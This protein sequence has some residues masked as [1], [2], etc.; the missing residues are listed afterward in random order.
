MASLSKNS[1]QIQEPASVY[2]SNGPNKPKN[3]I[4]K[5]IKRGSQIAQNNKPSTKD[6]N[7]ILYPKEPPPRKSSLRRREAMNPI[8]DLKSFL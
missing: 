7:S 3:Q 6:M 8:S 5:N 4:N 1:Q 2:E